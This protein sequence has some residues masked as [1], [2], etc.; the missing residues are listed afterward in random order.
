MPTD[1]RLI[2]FARR[3]RKEPSPVER[4]M[5]VLLRDRRLG[6]FRFRRKHPIPPYIADFYCAVTRLVVEL[7][8]ESHIGSEED[9]R[10]RQGFLE[11]AGYQ[12]IRF[13][14]NLVFD[15]PDTVI[16]EVYR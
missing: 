11:K 7:D 14:N 5:W 3:M 12:V 2:E 13:W 1:P 8:G 10:L 6:G 16:G 9:D 4:R 15:D